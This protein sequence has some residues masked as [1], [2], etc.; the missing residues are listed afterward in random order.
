[1]FQKASSKG[2]M[3]V[4]IECENFLIFFYRPSFEKVHLWTENLLFHL[5]HGMALPHELQGDPVQFYQDLKDKVLSKSSKCNKSDSE[6]SP[7]NLAK[8]EDESPKVE[9]K[10]SKKGHTR[11][12]SL[13]TITE[14]T[15]ISGAGNLS[16]KSVGAVIDVVDPLMHL[17]TLDMKEQCT[18]ELEDMQ[19]EM[20]DTGDLTVT[21]ETSDEHE[22]SSPERS[23]TDILPQTQGIDKETQSY[24]NGNIY[25]SNNS[26]LCSDI[27]TTH[28]T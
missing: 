21:G 23:I 5:E 1:M 19:I 15:K 24:T 11:K 7:D 10:G 20:C 28:S 3:K 26:T 25:M 14:S 6:S 9:R 13:S 17:N 8:S 4:V 27:Y 2:S 22:K 16:D 18:N 12:S